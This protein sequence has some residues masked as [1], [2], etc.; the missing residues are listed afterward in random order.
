MILKHRNPLDPVVYSRQ[1]VSYMGF[2]VERCLQFLL[3]IA[4]NSSRPLNEMSMDPQ[5]VVKTNSM[6]LITPQA[7]LSCA[8]TR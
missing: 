5:S 6:Q 2:S 4:L 8:A 1:M 7:A 3:S